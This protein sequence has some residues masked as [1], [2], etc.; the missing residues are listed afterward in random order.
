MIQPL[1]GGSTGMASGTWYGF[2]DGHAVVLN[3][4]TNR[5]NLITSAGTISHFGV[6]LTVA[7]GVGKSWTAKIFVNGVASSV[8]VTITGTDTSGSDTVNTAV[9]AAGDLV[10]LQVYRDANNASDGVTVD[11]ELVAVSLEYTTT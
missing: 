7:P 8:V 11:A 2:L 9:V 5:Q 6:T 10:I 3:A 1:L 4:V